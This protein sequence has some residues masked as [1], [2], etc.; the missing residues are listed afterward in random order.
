MMMAGLASAEMQRADR[1]NA[2]H[3][4]PVDRGDEKM[5]EFRDLLNVKLGVTPFD[6]GRVTDSSSLGPEGVLSVWSETKAG[7]RTYRVTS[8]EA[9][10][11][12]WQRTKSMRDA[13][14][15]R[16]VTTHRIDV[17]I[18]EP[19]AEKIKQVWTG[20]LRDARPA[21][22]SEVRY[23]MDG[24]LDFSIQQSAHSSSLYGHL[25]LPAPGPKTESLVKI[26]D[27]LWEYCKAAPENRSAIASK[28][29]R[30]VTRLLAQL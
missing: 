24:Y 17:Q 2:D 16:S 22:P 3:L 12:L 8:V 28:I 23:V 29:D 20:M 9:A 19:I 6:C 13:D 27:A 1:A 25:A 21:S 14:K 10:D 15:A 11:N 7:R 30:E 4:S 5:N 26:S 18:S